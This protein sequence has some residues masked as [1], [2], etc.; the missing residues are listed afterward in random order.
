[1]QGGKIER[2]IIL[3]LIIKSLYISLKEETPLHIIWQRGT[4][5]Q[6]LKCLGEKKVPTKEHTVRPSED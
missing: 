5:F 6:M 3:D 2:Q 4:Y 1:M